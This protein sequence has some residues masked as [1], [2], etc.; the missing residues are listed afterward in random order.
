MGTDYY[1]GVE[2]AEMST[3]GACSERNP[4]EATSEAGRRSTEA[5]VDAAVRFIERWKA[6]SPLSRR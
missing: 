1:A 6:L 4:A 3:T 2:E 5:F